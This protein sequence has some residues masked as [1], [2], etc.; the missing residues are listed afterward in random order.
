VCLALNPTGNRSVATANAFVRRLHDELRSDPSR[1]VQDKQFFGSVTTLRP[2]ALGAA[3]TRRILD[4]LGLDVASLGDEGGD[5]LTILR[6]TLMNPYLIDLE[7]GIS[8]IDLYFEHLATQ[9]Q[10][11]V[12]G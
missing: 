2:D 7:N 6:H 10:R 9:V 5:R 1:P 11:L 12:A 4:A 8:Y 3:E